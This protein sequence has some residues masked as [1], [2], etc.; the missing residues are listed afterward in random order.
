[1]SDA[2]VG[3]YVR[4]SEEAIRNAFK[5][6]RITM[7]R[8]ILR[9]ISSR[10]AQA[11]PKGSLNWILGALADEIRAMSLSVSK[12]I[13]KPT[14]KKPI[15]AGIKIDRLPLAVKRT[16]RKTAKKLAQELER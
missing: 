13:S 9:M 8:E 14:K 12:K 3:A 16:V 15:G 1:M 6:G 10:Q 2:E 4:A 7:R 11:I 5:L